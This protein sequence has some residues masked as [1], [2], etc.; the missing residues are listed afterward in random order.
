M[1]RD[2]E[3]LTTNPQPLAPSMDKA[4]QDQVSCRYCHLEGYLVIFHQNYT[5]QP[6]MEIVDHNGECKQVRACI[7]CHCSCEVG[8]FVRSVSTDDIKRR[9]PELQ[10][11]GHGAM[12]NWR[13]TDP[14]FPE[15]TAEERDEIP[16]WTA[17]R[18]RLKEGTLGSPVQH[19]K[20]PKDVNRYP[21]V[22][23]EVK[24]L[25]AI[26]QARSLRPVEDDYGT[27]EPD[28]VLETVPAFN[29]LDDPDDIP[30]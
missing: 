5:G 15:L 11:I 27:P 25:S 20:P 16:D 22:P 7:S 30:F 4:K 13:A 21:G 18:K 23:A 28:P 3:P 29:E 2:A 1:K 8:R 19:V 14:R 24:R 9:T 17:F 12:K 10:E 6:L 26:E